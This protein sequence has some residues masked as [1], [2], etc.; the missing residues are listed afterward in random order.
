MLNSLFLEFRRKKELEHV[1]KIQR[2]LKSSPL[3]MT[4]KK[5]SSMYLTHSSAAQIKN[6]IT[7]TEEFNSLLGKIGLRPD[8]YVDSE[9]K[10]KSQ[11]NS[12][13]L[14]KFK[15][16]HKPRASMSPKKLAKNTRNG[17]ISPFR[18]RKSAYAHKLK[19]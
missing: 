17:Q 10:K 9:R 3:R 8:G 11:G 2:I 19:N 7:N 14:Q 4:G 1:K 5:E 15:L 13:D 12:V 6:Q 18:G 16:K